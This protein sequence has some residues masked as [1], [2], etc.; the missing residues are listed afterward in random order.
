MFTGRRYQPVSQQ[1]DSE[2]DSDETTLFTAE[3][4]SSQKGEWQFGVRA[5]DL[6][7]DLD[8]PRVR[9]VHPSSKLNK[10]KGYSRKQALFGACLF[11]VIVATVTALGVLFLMKQ[12]YAVIGPATTSEPTTT[13]EPPTTSEQATTASPSPVEE[14]PTIEKC[15]RP[16]K[17]LENFGG[18]NGRR[19]PCGGGKTPPKPIA[20]STTQSIAEIKTEPPPIEETEHSP[21]EGTTV[22]P[23]EEMKTSPSVEE[24]TTKIRVESPITSSVE[25]PIS[26]PTTSQPLPEAAT[27]TSEATT[28]PS[29]VGHKSTTLQP[30]GESPTEP[31]TTPTNIDHSLS[32][33]TTT[34]TEYDDLLHD[35]SNKISSEISPSADSTTQHSPSSETTTSAELSHVTTQSAEL[36]DVL[37]SEANKGNGKVSPT[38]EPRSVNWER[39]FFPAMSESTTELFDINRD[40]VMD[41][42]IVEDYSE[43]GSRIIAMDGEKGDKFW[44]KE[45]NFPAF[46]V[47][48]E[49][50]VNGDDAM[51]CLVTGR[52]GGFAAID[53]RD[54]SILWEVEPS[55]VFPRYNFYFPLIVKDLNNDGVDDLINMHGGDVTY[56]PQQHDRSP[57]LLVV[58]SGKTGQSLMPPMLTPD[59]HET[60]MSP[61]LFKLNGKDDFVLFGT[62][63]ETV[64]GS[65][66]GVSLLSIRTQ[67]L[68][69]QY[70]HKGKVEPYKPF[71][72]DTYH[73][74]LM[75]G[76]DMNKLRPTFDQTAYDFQR[77]I[78]VTS[79]NNN[80]RFCPRWENVRPIWNKYGVCLYELVKAEFKGVMIPPVI[81]DLDLDG[82]DDL[83]V[84]TY[85]GHTIALN[86]SD[87]VTRLWDVYYPS[88]E[89]YRY[90]CV[91]VCLYVISEHVCV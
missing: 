62:G 76:M 81:V 67:V 21:S 49:L 30:E 83:V 68:K 40:G 88:T 89:S 59:G 10:I 1:G 51:D 43:C 8:L 11:I 18:S 77:P 4:G 41:V 72:N 80:M 61:V 47:R 24:A 3:N 86:G 35:W 7:Q 79:S 87:A 26:S 19:P 55:I 42:V 36:H 39:D 20:S 84:S 37:T 74:C 34:S 91:F 56:K 69:H 31:I 65:L 29:D 46:A 38:S 12:S 50:D 16:P 23:S 70:S 58:I 63:G 90:V 44:Q 78:F 13:S 32:S 64:P 52:G 82:I 14:E 66:W 73:P 57:G 15:D 60:Y 54:G 33:I 48:C 27:T 9:T 2:S 6:S 53:P 45:V 25:V 75:Q 22:P 5:Y 17:P 28:P 85:D 71:I